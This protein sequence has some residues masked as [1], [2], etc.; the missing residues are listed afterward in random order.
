M[1]KLLSEAIVAMSS[2]YP[3]TWEEL[4]KK[5]MDRERKELEEKFLRSEEDCLKSLD[6]SLEKG[7]YKTILNDI[8]EFIK[9]DKKFHTALSVLRKIHKGKDEYKS[10][11]PFETFSK[12]DVA[13]Y[14]IDIMKPVIK[15]DIKIKSY[16][17]LHYTS[18]TWGRGFKNDDYVYYNDI[19]LKYKNKKK[20]T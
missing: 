18:P 2:D 13:L 7:E 20:S 17:G 14:F 3:Q 19:V 11:I 10:Y 12:D 9:K 8:I 15:D 5:R 4:Y 16:I 1:S 6:R